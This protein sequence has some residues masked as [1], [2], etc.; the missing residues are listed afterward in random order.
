MMGMMG[1]NFDLIERDKETDIESA[2]NCYNAALNVFTDTEFPVEW[3]QLQYQLGLVERSIS[4]F[5]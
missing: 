4:F 1:L 3:A 2:I 5:R